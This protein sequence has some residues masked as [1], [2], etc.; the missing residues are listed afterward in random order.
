MILLTIE[1]LQPTPIHA[2]VTHLARDK[3]QIT[4]ALKSLE[5]K[6]MIKRQTAEDDGRVV[7]VA[8]TDTGQHMVEQLQ[9]VL[10]ETIGEILGPLAAEDHA[11]LETLLR[12][13]VPPPGRAQS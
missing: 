1:E 2:L 8:L 10:A 4:R 9:V 13:V 5:T 11:V 7:V 12:R 3:S 6:G